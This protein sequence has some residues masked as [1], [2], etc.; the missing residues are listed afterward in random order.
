[1]RVVAAQERHWLEN[2]M[3]WVTST[4]FINPNRT[5]TTTTATAESARVEASGTMAMQ[6]VGTR[7]EAA[8]FL[9]GRAKK[10]MLPPPKAV[11][12]GEGRTPLGQAV[13]VA[14]RTVAR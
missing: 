13:V 3:E 8:I 7:Q 2:G 1:M 4:P 6:G 11:H 14:V 10:Q 9:E 12:S 5:T